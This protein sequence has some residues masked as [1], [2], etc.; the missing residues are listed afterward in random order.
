MTG[1]GIE[2]PSPGILASTLYIYIY[3]YIYRER[4]M[5]WYMLEWLALWH[6]N[7]F[8]VILFHNQLYNHGF[9]LYIALIRTKEVN[10][11]VGWGCKTLPHNECPGYDTKQ[12][13]GE[14]LVMRENWG[15]QST[16]SLPSLPG[17]FGLGV[18]APDW[19]QSMGQIEL[20]YVLRLNWITWNRTVLIFKLRT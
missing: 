9:Q 18:A 20:N 4:E 12:S 5:N 2:H 7:P 16:T 1:P 6:V 19:V 14:V 10:C 11:R 8:G 17:R 15:I 3:I 13:N